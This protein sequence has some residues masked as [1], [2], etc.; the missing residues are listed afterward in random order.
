VVRILGDGDKMLMPACSIFI[1]E[2]DKED[3]N[4]AGYLSKNE[5]CIIMFIL[6]F[7]HEFIY[8]PTYIGSDARAR[9]GPRRRRHACAHMLTATI[10]TAQQQ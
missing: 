7:L 6:F 5:T 9:S 10:L 8:L 4:A 1:M 2:Q 3:M